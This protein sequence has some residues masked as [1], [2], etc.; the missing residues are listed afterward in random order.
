[1]KDLPVVVRIKDKRIGSMV[2][3][4]ADLQHAETRKG[5]TGGQAAAR[6]NQAAAILGSAPGRTY[7][8]VAAFCWEEQHRRPA[9]GQTR[10]AAL[11]KRGFD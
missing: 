3:G 5:M 8:F 4:D 1:L 6:G 11:H 9:R 10:R 2:E 7:C